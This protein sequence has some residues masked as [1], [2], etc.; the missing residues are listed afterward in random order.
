M[1]DSLLTS[2]FLIIALQAAVP[3][4]V[5][6]VRQYTPEQLEER[7]KITSQVIAEKGDVIQFRSKTK[8][9]TASAFN[10]LAEGLAILATQKGG[11]DFLGQHWEY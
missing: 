6:T 11:V 1:H 7:R 10:H 4:W 5:E 3:L 8:G 9:E 2:D